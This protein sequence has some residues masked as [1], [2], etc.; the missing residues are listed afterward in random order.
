MTCCAVWPRPRPLSGLR[1]PECWPSARRSCR[2]GSARRPSGA[3]AEVLGHV[4]ESASN[5]RL[6]RAFGAA[7]P[8]LT[9]A[10]VVAP[11]AAPVQLAGR[12]LSLRG[13]SCRRALPARPT[14]TT[15]SWQKQLRQRWLQ[16]QLL[17]LLQ[18]WQ[19][20]RVPRQGL[21]APR[22]RRQLGPLHRR[23]TPLPAALRQRR[24]LRNPALK[25][26][27]HLRRSAASRRAPSAGTSVLPC[28]NCSRTSR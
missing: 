26:R 6:T 9:G 15:S 13:R 7:W 25:T 14:G 27:R 18:R 2:D 28:G 16:R 24:R 20:R 3:F 19:R 4:A 21:Q 12:P 1:G 22:R 8:T 23:P 11:A 17:Q 10:P 5:V